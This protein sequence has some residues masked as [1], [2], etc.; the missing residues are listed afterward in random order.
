MSSNLSYENILNH[1]LDIDTVPVEDYLDDNGLLTGERSDILVEEA[2]TKAQVD[3]GR[4]Y[5]GDKNKSVSRFILHPKLTNPIART[6]RFFELKLARKVSKRSKR[7]FRGLWETLAPGSTVM[8]TSPTT[9]IKE[10]GVPEV[11]VR[12]SDIAKFGTQAKRNTEQ[13]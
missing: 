12:N 10:P 5:N 3:A 13:W 11:K 7:D 4:R 2:M 8:R 1:Y 6:E 9:A